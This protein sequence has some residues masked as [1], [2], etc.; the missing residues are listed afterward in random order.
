MG[1][2]VRV[3]GVMTVVLGT[4]S[5]TTTT[6]VAGDEHTI[7]VTAGNSIQAAIDKAHPGDTVL[8]KP[9]TY[10]ENLV[11]TTDRV[12]LRGSGRSNTFLAPPATTPATAPFNL[13]ALDFF[14]GQRGAGVCVFGQ[15]DPSNGN[16]IKPVTGVHVSNLTVRDFAGVGGH[17]GAGVFGYGTDRFQVTH[18][19]ASNNATYGISRFESTRTLFEFN[20]AWGSAEAG[21]YIGDS[22]NADTVVKHNESWGNDLGIFVRHARGVTVQDNDVHGNCFGILVLMDGQPG[23]AGNETIRENSFHDNNVFCP[24]SSDPGGPPP[25]GGAGVVLLGADHTLVADNEI[26]GNTGSAHSLAG[27]V[28]V[29]SDAALFP[30]GTDAMDNTVRDNE[31]RNNARADIFY[32]GKGSGNRFLE[33]DCSTSVPPGLCTQNENHQ[34]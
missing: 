30:G 12:T 25:H 24:G 5:L 8:V 29:L 34:H 21:F 20:R 4:V 23:G 31:F 15:I 7:V 10:H 6:V 18:V 3:L 14:F 9:G 27:G 1:W 22:P 13:C 11:I 26:S 19:D 32:D 28:L 33:N 2:R 17:G 16:V